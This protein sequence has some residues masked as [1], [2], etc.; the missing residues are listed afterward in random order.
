[1]NRTWLKEMRQ[2]AN[3][4]QLDMAK[5]LDITE[6]YYSLVESGK[7]QTPMDMLFAS[8]IGLIF[9]ITLNDISALEIN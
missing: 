2:K 4:T 3:M 5:K 7:R 9:G 8:K 6:S 1:M